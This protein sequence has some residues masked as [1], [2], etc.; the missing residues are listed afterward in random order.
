MGKT[1]I[2]YKE[3]FSL[4]LPIYGGLLASQAI[5]VADVFF[6]G[7]IDSVQQSAAAY[8]GLLYTVFFLIGYGLTTGGQIL[9]ARRIGEGNLS[10][11]GK[12]FWN[13][14]MVSLVY[15]TLVALFFTF[16]TKPL[17]QFLL[18]S[19]EVSTKAAEYMRFRSFGFIGTQISWCF[20][21]YNIGRGSSIAV[22]VASVVNAIVNIVLAWIFIFGNMGFSGNEIRGAALASGIADVCC[23]LTYVV[24]TL[25]NKDYLT[26]QIQKFYLFSTLQLKQLFKV[27]SPLIIQNSLSITAWFLFFAWIEHT[28]KAN[29]E[30]STIMRVVYSVFMMSPIA[31]ASSTNSLVSNIIGQKRHDEVIPLIYKII[32]LSFLFALTISPLMILIPDLL[33]DI[34]TK[35]DTLVPLAQLPLRSIFVA[36]MFFSISNIFFQSVSGTGNTH[37]ALLIEVF[38]IAIYLVYSYYVTYLSPQP[39]WVIWLAE[40]IYMCSFGI[41]SAIYIHSGRWKR[42]K[43]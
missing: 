32:K 1:S 35:D 7:K 10:E 9:I 4:A 18:H 39:L 38:C 17:F 15:A 24:F 42:L 26:Y 13:L 2:T 22:T 40:V 43:I 28:G 30:I 37:I 20:C 5:V 8:G 12:H 41:L 23:A 21:A 33:I 31:L 3:V 6:L 34:F 29:F 19:E 27:S 14:I 25:V 16:F 36:L 11:V